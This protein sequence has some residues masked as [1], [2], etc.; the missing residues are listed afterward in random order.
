MKVN[1]FHPYSPADRVLGLLISTGIGR[2]AGGGGGDVRFLLALSEMVGVEAPKLHFSI[3]T[4]IMTLPEPLTW[5]SRKRKNLKEL[6]RSVR[7]P[8]N[9]T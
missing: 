1:L 7:R 6:V 2:L 9:L 8:L 4:S 5:S 3:S